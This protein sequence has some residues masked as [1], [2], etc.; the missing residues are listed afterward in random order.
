MPVFKVRCIGKGSKMTVV[1]ANLNQLKE[2]ANT[3]FQLQVA[4]ASSFKVFD[5][6][7]GSLID[8]DAC[9]EALVTFANNKG[10]HL[11]LAIAQLGEEWSRSDLDVVANRSGGADTPNQGSDR[12]PS[13]DVDTNIAPT[14]MTSTVLPALPYRE[15]TKKLKDALKSPSHIRN[16]VITRARR[17]VVKTLTEK[18]KNKTLLPGTLTQVCKKIH[19]ACPEAFVVQLKEGNTASCLYQFSRSLYNA[20]GYAKEVEGIR[21]RQRRS[22]SHVS[23]EDA[24]NPEELPFIRMDTNGCAEGMWA[25]PLCDDLLDE[26]EVKRRTLFDLASQ[27]SGDDALAHSLMKSTYALQRHCIN[28]AR[29]VA[30]WQDLVEKW[31]IMKKQSFLICHASILLGKEVLAVW[32]SE[33]SSSDVIFNFLADYADKHTAGRAEK[34][35]SCLEEAQEAVVSCDSSVPKRVALFPLLALYLGDA[36]KEFFLLV[37]DPL[38]S[39]EEMVLK[40]S[41][42]SKCPLLVVNGFSIFDAAARAFVV[43]RGELVVEVRSILDG[44]LLVVLSY[45]VYNIVYPK[46]IARLLEFMQR[47]FLNINSPTRVNAKVSSLASALADFEARNSSSDGFFVIELVLPSKVSSQLSTFTRHL[48]S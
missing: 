7:D 47:F 37:R 25:P 4:S 30:Q 46:R 10:E 8:D 40:A 23:E 17:S 48:I 43:V 33:L 39:V 2:G 9:L 29:T 35:K 28:G 42:V 1:A 14:S 15:V 11:S 31:P 44:V 16:Q 24:D 34:M 22:T 5:D 20:L 19:S 18:L 26:L 12:V 41:G 38:A 45:F 21:R 3:K 13:E 36:E 6:S 32:N 27:T